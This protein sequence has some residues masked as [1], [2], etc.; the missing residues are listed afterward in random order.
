VYLEGAIYR[1]DTGACE[2]DKGWEHWWAKAN[3]S[4]NDD[5]YCAI[6]L[7]LKILSQGGNDTS[8]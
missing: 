5:A 6:Q 4:M 7:L 8:F 1:Q 3:L 2:R